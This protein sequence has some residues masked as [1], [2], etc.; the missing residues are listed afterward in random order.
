MVDSFDAFLSFTMTVVCLY[1]SLWV[2]E[3]R[4]LSC[5]C[6]WHALLHMRS[7]QQRVCCF[8]HSLPTNLACLWMENNYI[9]KR[10]LGLHLQYVLCLD[11]F[12]L[13]VLS[14]LLLFLYVLVLNNFS[15]F[16]LVLYFPVVYQKKNTNFLF[17]F[18]IKPLTCFIG[19]SLCLYMLGMQSDFCIFYFSFPLIYAPLCSFFALWISWQKGGEI[20]LWN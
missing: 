7:R 9:F 2:C 12:E 16:F 5:V 20:V 3:S 15:L 19:Y 17:V 1:C 14:V 18:K 8:F 11:C 4:V 13:S 10:T 6:P